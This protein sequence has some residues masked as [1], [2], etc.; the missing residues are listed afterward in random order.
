MYHWITDDG[1]LREAWRHFVGAYLDWDAVR[2]RWRTLSS[3]FQSQWNSLQ[4]WVT[5]SGP[6]RVAFMCSLYICSLCSLYL[7]FIKSSR[8]SLRLTL[9]EFR[10]DRLEYLEWNFS[11]DSFKTLKFG[12]PKPFLSRCVSYLRFALLPWWQ[13]RQLGG[14]LSIVKSW[15]RFRLWWLLMAVGC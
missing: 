2:A 10:I 4:N 1:I 7:I 14:A 9:S 5:W 13:R 15:W 8:S 6:R 3:I 11:N 12:S